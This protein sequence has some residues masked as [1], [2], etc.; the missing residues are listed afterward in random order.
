MLT[1]VCGFLAS[2]DALLTE[3]AGGDYSGRQRFMAT[4]A[5]IAA[6]LGAMVAAVSIVVVSNAFRISAGERAA[7]FGILKSVG[8][9]K[10]QIAAT[11]M[12]EGVWLSAVGI[13]IGIALGMAVHFAGVGIANY[14]LISINKLNS[15]GDALLNLQF[16]VKWWA[17]A[18]SAVFSFLTVLISAWLPA[19]KAARVPAIDA[20]R[21]AG[22]VKIKP[23]RVRTSPF[24]QKIFGFEGALAAKSLKRSR[25]NF[26]ATVVS[27]AVSIALVI[28][29]D[30]VMTYGVNITDAYY[31]E[32]DVN[33]VAA[34]ENTIRYTYG[35]NGV[36][37]RETYPI[38]YT[39]AE[40]VT[41]KLRGYPETTVI[42]VGSDR[43]TYAAV[44]PQ[45]MLTPRMREY[46]GFGQDSYRVSATLVTV[47]SETYA[48]LR[49]KAGAGS[50]ANLLVNRVR[51]SENG[52]RADFEPFV[53]QNQ[54]LE[55]TDRYALTPPLE[56]PLHGVLSANDVPNELTALVQPYV[57][58]VIV[59]EYDALSYEWLAYTADAEGF[60]A[61]AKGALTD[62]LPQD[63]PYSL[64]VA[65]IAD[66]TDAL[67]DM[68]NLIL[69]FIY[70]FV[71]MLIL[72]GLTN[73]ISTISTNVRS[74]AREFAV[75]RS[76]GMTD[77]GIKKMLNL[78][79]ILSSA[80][81]LLFGLPAGCA[82]SYLMYVS[83][84]QSAYFAYAFPWA[85][86]IQ[87]ALGVFVITWVT[88]RYSA[89][90]LR[91]G[92]IVETIRAEG[93]V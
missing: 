80:R 93:A 9:T 19:R 24:I 36:T 85:P 76:V 46:M 20:I 43:V 90:K 29:A 12:Y 89:S 65:N 13:P 33:V 18:A 92:S 72:V 69:T 16:V 38:A 84:I 53:F 30:G 49:E 14:Y 86:V 78:E 77:G 34:Y 2:G 8:A 68:R 7:Q 54:I 55:L 25:R 57:I 4:L 32:L 91:G 39:F 44:L 28:A 64:D 74:R 56:L 73:V 63:A 79:S 62:M 37:G 3:I 35:E 41:G 61:F 67:R 45:A 71:G 17:V 88:M 83:T 51:I 15:G 22:E 5:G 66:I 23:K 26:R 87:C 6:V 11:V 40:Q 21:G 27:L 48:R 42:G 58:T 52:E 82:L 50:G 31:M 81:A 70:G 59:P 10:K 60:T 75:L 1:T 47:D